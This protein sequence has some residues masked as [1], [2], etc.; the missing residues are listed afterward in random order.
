M[1][2]PLRI[3]HLEDSEDDAFLIARALKKRW[4]DAEITRLEGEEELR[5][6]L[7]EKGWDAVLSDQ[8]MPGFNAG[9][10]LRIVREASTDI[11]FIVVSGELAMEDAVSLMKAGAHDFVRKDD[12]ARLIPA[13]E[14]E[15]EEAAVRRERAAG[16]ETLE[17]NEY[18]FRV[19]ADMYEMADRSLEEVTQFVLDRAVELTSSSLGFVGFMNEDESVLRIL[20][21]SKEVM[22]ECE[23]QDKPLDFPVGEA[24]LWSEAIR[25]RQPVIVNDYD[26]P[27]PAKRGCPAGHVALTRFLGY[28]HIVDGKV[29]L[30]AGVANKVTDYSPAEVRQLSLLLGGAWQIMKRK[31]AEEQVRR[32][33]DNLE[34]IL[35]FMD[36]GIYIVD[37]DFQ[38]QFANPAIE[39]QFGPLDGRK[40]HEY[41]YGLDEACPWCKNPEVFAGE[42]VHW[43]FENPTTGRI[44][45]MIDTPITNPDGS[46]SKL[47][48]LNDVTDARR[49]QARLQQ[50]EKMD[51][52]GNLAGG[53]AHDLKNMLFP[54]IN[55]TRMAL[56]ALPEDDRGRTRLEKVVE[57]AER[58]RSLTEKIHAFS[59]TDEMVKERRDLRTLITDS[60]EILRPSIPRNIDIESGFEDDVGV[61]EVDVAQFQTMI[62]NLGSNAADAI[63]PKI[64][65]IAIS[66][67]KVRLDT[68]RPA[69]IPVPDVGF[70]ARLVV[71]DTGEGMDE[72][73]VE[74]IFEPYFTTKERGKGTGLGMAMIQKFVV[75]HGGGITVVSAPGEGTAFEIFFPVVEA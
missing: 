2:P 30:V 52:L 45:D 47:K 46:V 57:A 51:A 32:E 10:A 44:Y 26:A 69:V 66:A 11:P 6:A 53:I 25:T 64:G 39:K 70:Y 18:R 43:E 49:A 1:P 40:C 71:A 65:R 24:A 14:R 9:Q 74:H 21:W 34:S 13:L 50:A 61:V 56:K 22:K 28:P 55:L 73:T 33:R 4:S 27:H 63:G 42:T 36:V 48:F 8:V 72:E 12:L 37:Q 75:E 62:L 19:L 38:I 41:F 29:V 58:A 16:R 5:A 31:Q 68:I 67:S 23:I 3:L 54:I 17:E 35:A 60:L 7:W 59:H 15:L 20:N